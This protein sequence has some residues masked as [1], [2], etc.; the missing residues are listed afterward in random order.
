MAFGLD[1]AD[2]MLALI[3]QTLADPSL[4]HLVVGGLNPVFV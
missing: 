1:F 2:N 4:R 3:I